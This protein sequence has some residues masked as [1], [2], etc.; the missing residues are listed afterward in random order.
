MPAPGGMRDPAPRPASSPD[1]RPLTPNAPAGFH[2]QP[3]AP[4]RRPPQSLAG[5]RAQPQYS[6]GF[7]ERVGTLPIIVGVALLS[8]VIGMILTWWLGW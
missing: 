1:L 7:E 2:T 4:Q 6:Q 3:P 8:C 5:F